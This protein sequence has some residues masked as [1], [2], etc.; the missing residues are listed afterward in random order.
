MIDGVR[1]ERRQDR[2]R[3][4]EHDQRPTTKCDRE[5]DRGPKALAVA[6]PLVVGR[7]P[8]EHP[9]RTH[10]P[11]RGHQLRGGEGNDPQAE[12]VRSDDPSQK[13][14]YPQG[15]KVADHPGRQEQRGLS[16]EAPDG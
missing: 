15:P 14:R 4:A 11:E 10:E 3:G 8:Y 9:V 7:L 6:D 12:A 5:P 1:Q 2:Q 16:R 13:D